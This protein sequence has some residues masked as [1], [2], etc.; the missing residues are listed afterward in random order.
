[1]RPGSPGS[2]A[3]KFPS[4]ASEPS[5]R[6]GRAHDSTLPPEERDMATYEP[7]NQV[8]IEEE[9][10]PEDAGQ[11]TLVGLVKHFPWVAIAVLIHVLVIVVLSVVYM[12]THYKA[13]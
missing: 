7:R 10:I 3:S 12:S 5:L 8:P 2:H 1:M 4:S 6:E 13:K 9:P 11:R